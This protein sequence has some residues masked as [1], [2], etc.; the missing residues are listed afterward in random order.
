[1]YVAYS[2]TVGIRKKYNVVVNFVREYFLTDT[3]STLFSDSIKIQQRDFNLKGL[4]QQQKTLLK[5]YIQKT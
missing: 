3:Q 2:T 5:L 1:M 4:L